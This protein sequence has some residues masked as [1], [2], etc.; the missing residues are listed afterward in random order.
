MT[1]NFPKLMSDTKPQSKETKR[2]PSRI[3]EAKTTPKDIIFK[4]QKIKDKEQNLERSQ[5]NKTPCIKRNKDKNYQQLLRNHASKK[6]VSEIYK[7]LKKIPTNLEFCTFEI[8][9]QK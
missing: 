8:I 4:W 6:R 9:L 7:V 3:S 5:R 1:E 2:T